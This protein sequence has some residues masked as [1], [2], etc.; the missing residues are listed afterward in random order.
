MELSKACNFLPRDLLLAKLSSN[1]FD[2]SEVALIANYFSN[3]C[4]RAKIGS[5]LSSH[6]E[7]LRGVP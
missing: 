2:E 1:R 7:I 4:Q 5:T 3:R 6:L